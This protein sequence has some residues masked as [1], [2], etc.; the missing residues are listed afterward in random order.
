[1]YAFQKSCYNDIK[2]PPGQHFHPFQP[3][4]GQ[5]V[6]SGYLLHFLQQKVL[7]VFVYSIPQNL[8]LF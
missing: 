6:G 1:M 8:R 3:H 7:T 5:T 4:G 2:L